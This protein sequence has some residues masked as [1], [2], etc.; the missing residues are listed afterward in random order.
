MSNTQTDIV[1]TV[2]EEMVNQV[3]TEARDTENYW[4]SKFEIAQG[5]VDKLTEE[6]EKLMKKTISATLQMETIYE[7]CQELKEQQRQYEN[8][9]FVL[10]QDIAGLKA[11]N[12]KLGALAGLGAEAVLKHQKG[13]N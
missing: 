6:N 12:V 13:A 4:K 5:Q 7:V 10:Q 9:I 3:E 11:K 2:V 1:R 8:K